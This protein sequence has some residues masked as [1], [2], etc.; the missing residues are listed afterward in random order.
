MYRTL[1]KLFASAATEHVYLGERL[2]SAKWLG[3]EPRADADAE[4]GA[5]ARSGG[6]CH[7]PEL[8]ALPAGGK[9]A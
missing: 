1:Q 6:D 5:A 2:Q 9:P 8:L 7:A 4:T 3:W